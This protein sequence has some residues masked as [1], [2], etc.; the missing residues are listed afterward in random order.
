MALRTTPHGYPIV[1]SKADGDGEVI[2][3]H[4]EGHPVHPYV[5]WRMTA[6]GDCHHGDYCLTL[7]DAEMS[8]RRRTA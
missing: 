2:I 4:R 1:M 8:L 6:S 7:R 5:T 3:A